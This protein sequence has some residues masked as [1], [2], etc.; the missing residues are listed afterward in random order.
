LCLLY[1]KQLWLLS[2]AIEFNVRVVSGLADK[3]S[4]VTVP[5]AGKKDSISTLKACSEN[6][7]KSSKSLK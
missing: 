1:C 4:L 6:K 7:G 5:A 2:L 3:G